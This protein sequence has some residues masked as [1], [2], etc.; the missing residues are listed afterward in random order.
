MTDE[1]RHEYVVVTGDLR[2]AI[3]LVIDKGRLMEIRPRQPQAEGKRE[4]DG[5]SFV[6]IPPYEELYQKLLRTG[7]HMT[8]AQREAAAQRMWVQERLA[9]YMSDHEELG[10]YRS[11]LR[12]RILAFNPDMRSEEARGFIQELTDGQPKLYNLFVENA[13]QER[14]EIIGEPEEQGKG[15]K[16]KQE[17]SRQVIRNRRLN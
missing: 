9:Q 15:E 11:V 12:G 13:K 8:E 2:Q 4:K 7:E 16:P 6:W 3:G 1:G 10:G 17:N 5:E 14:K